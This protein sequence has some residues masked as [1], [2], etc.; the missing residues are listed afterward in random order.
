MLEKTASPHTLSAKHIDREA[1]TLVS[2]IDTERVIDSAKRLPEARIWSRP[3]VRTL[4]DGQ[5]NLI[6]FESELPKLTSLTAS[7][8]FEISLGNTESGVFRLTVEL[9]RKRLSIWGQARLRREPSQMMMPL[10]SDHQLPLA[11][12][13]IT[14]DQDMASVTESIDARG[15]QSKVSSIRSKISQAKKKKSRKS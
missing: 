11:F 2:Q 15:D 8:A 7:T 3:D 6:S 4:D 1:V 13:A 10:V 5:E 12:E 14:D 9:T